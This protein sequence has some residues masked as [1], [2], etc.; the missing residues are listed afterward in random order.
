M[1]IKEFFCSDYMYRDIRI[2]QEVKLD[3]SSDIIKLD[4]DLQNYLN[5]ARI[6]AELTNVPGV[7]H[8]TD[9]FR[10]NGT[11]YIVMEL[12]DGSSLEKILQNGTLL[13]WKEAVTSFLPIIT[14][15]SIIHGKGLIHRDIKPDNIIVS[16]DG[17]FTLIDFGAALHITV[18]E[19]YSVYLTEGYAPK[20]QYQRTGILSPCTD[21]YALCAVIYRCITG[22]VPQHSIQRAVCDE[23]KTPTELNIH[24]PNELEKVLIKGLQIEPENRWKNM[25]E[26]YDALESV[27]PKPKKHNR[28]I[29]VLIGIAAAFLFAVSAYLMSHRLEIK[30]N[31]MASDG[32]A[33]VFRLGAPE[34]MTADEFKEA[35]RLIEIRADAFAGS[36]NYL[37][38]TD[39]SSI[40]LTIPR[41]CFDIGDDWSTEFILYTCF[42]FS[43]KWLL[44]NSD[45][46]EFFELGPENINELELS[47][48]KIP[49]ITRSGEPMFYTGEVIDWSSED[50]YYLKMELNSEN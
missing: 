36:D 49:I 16:D 45:A 47:Y 1:A 13:T 9:F 40:T 28:V 39:A 30:M 42:S 33:I 23:L 48:G 17:S 12:I 20:E 41:D 37:I 6:L 29:Y 4:R 46:S 8:V 10:E 34:G 21:V 31:K 11:A 24:I 43:G 44:H 32:D 50:T 5:E 26:L 25:E 14:A 19:T 35:I 2:S 15:L 7:V 27:L 22:L 3:D 18:E 38:S